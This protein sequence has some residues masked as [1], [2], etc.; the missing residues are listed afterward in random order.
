MDNTEIRRKIL[1]LIHQKNLTKPKYMASRDE[2]QKE[3]GIDNADLDN[4]ILYLESKKLLKLHK[5]IGAIFL[6]AEITSNG[7]DAIE[8]PKS[9]EKNPTHLTQIIQGNIGVVVG[10]TN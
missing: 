2:L 3:L 5:G 9:N 1:E 10:L 7:I 8:N 4:N 6:A